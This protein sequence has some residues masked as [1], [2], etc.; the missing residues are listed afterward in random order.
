MIANFIAARVKR[1]STQFNPGLLSRDDSQLWEDVYG[2]RFQCTTWRSREERR[3]LQRSIYLFIITVANKK[4]KKKKSAVKNF[5]N[6]LSRYFAGHRSG[7]FRTIPTTRAPLNDETS[8][9]E[10]GKFETIICWQTIVSFRRRA[11]AINNKEHFREEPS[12]RQPYQPLNVIEN[13][14]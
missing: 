9:E 12:L 5:S 2:L 8:A 10:D 1:C 13:S 3:T 14:L 6:N 7:C 11:S 4:K